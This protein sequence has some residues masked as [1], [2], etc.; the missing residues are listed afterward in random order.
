[1]GNPVNA[2][3]MRVLA[4]SDSAFASPTNPANTQLVECIN[5]N[6]G[7]AAELGRT[8]PKQDRNL[9]RGYT[10]GF[11]TGR[12]EAIPF[13]LTTS[14]KSRSANDADPKELAL[15]KASGLHR[16]VNSGVSQVFTLP[17][18]PIGATDL[19]TCS[20]LRAF[21]PDLYRYQV[22][23]LI[24]CLVRQ[25]EISG[26]D[27]ELIAKFSGVGVAK[28]NGGY[29]SSITLAD[30]SG[31]ALTLS[32]TDSYKMGAPLFYQCE[33]EIIQ[34][35]D[36]NASMGA[37]SR[38]IA[39]AQLSS[40]GA[41]HAAKP[42]YPYFPG[43]LSPSGSPIPETQHTVSIDSISHRCL[44]F[45]LSIDTG[46]DLLTPETGSAH[47]QG[48][49]SIRAKVSG[50]VKLNLKQED[51]ADI[52]KAVNRKS[53]AISIVCGTAAGGIFTFS[54][55]QCELRPFVVPDTAN[56]IAVVDIP[57]EAFDSSSGND[58][59]TLTMT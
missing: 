25:I 19:V 43:S 31:T 13:E 59:L 9:G 49:K 27:K 34:M 4:G 48:S 33:N 23:W 46:V 56:D 55:P 22:E 1:M 20:L 3:D 53:V 8:R 51:I 21:G 2:W 54:L 15:L 16:V 39:R 14:L 52:G 57:F 11:V 40:T 28:V 12:V 5:V 32:A 18:D 58:Q 37:T 42:L 35:A 29:V 7:P 10:N 26:G 24:G 6:L 44:S 50:S 41:A 47:I 17:A 36:T 30:G 45:S 38:T